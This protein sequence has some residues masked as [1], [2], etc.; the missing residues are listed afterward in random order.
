MNLIHK[1]GLKQIVLGDGG[2]WRGGGGGF[3]FTKVN[4]PPCGTISLAS[5]HFSIIPK[6][7]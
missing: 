2:G 5:G 7:S 3:F 4:K 1:Y 6:F